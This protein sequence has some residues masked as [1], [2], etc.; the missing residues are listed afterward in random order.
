MSRCRLD[1]NGTILTEYLRSSEKV[2]ESN[3]SRKRQGTR[4]DRDR[5][6]YQDLNLNRRTEA[7]RDLTRVQD[8]W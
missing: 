5:M 6:N 8:N 1:E 7:I 3:R 4:A 2:H